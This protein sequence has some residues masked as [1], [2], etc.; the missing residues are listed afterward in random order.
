MKILFNN[1]YF[2]FFALLSLLVFTKNCTNSEVIELPKLKKISPKI[3]IVAYIYSII[4]KDGEDLVVVDVIDYNINDNSAN[5]NESNR[6]DLPNGYSI[7]NE[8]VELMEKIISDSVDITMQ[9][10]NYDDY[11]NFKFN[12]KI[13]SDTFKQVFLNTEYE[14]YKHIPF[15]ITLVDNQIT[16]ITE[17]YMP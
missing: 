8:K 1:P 12:E 6:I 3:E 4:K 10:L 17:I 13:D 9:T 14:R 7:L 5:Q 16:S 2:R 11:G 15:K